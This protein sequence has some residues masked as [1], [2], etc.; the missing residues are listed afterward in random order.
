MNVSPTD[1]IDR[2][3]ASPRQFETAQAV[4]ENCTAKELE[5]LFLRIVEQLKDT[6]GLEPAIEELK[7]QDT[8]L[9]EECQVTFESILSRS[10]ELCKQKKL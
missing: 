3:Q 2:S 10:E 7:I 8:H 4:V 6:D 9:F 1:M 5:C